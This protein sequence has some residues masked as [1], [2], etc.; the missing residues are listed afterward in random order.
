MKTLCEDKLCDALELKNCIK[1][2]IL[3]EVYGATKLKRKA[4]QLLARNMNSVIE[5]EDWES[6]A[7]HH[8]AL[9]TEVMR[10]IVNKKGTKRKIDLVK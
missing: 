7:K 8:P 5:T 2:L 9:G 10:V 1:N 4:I 3:G 6:C